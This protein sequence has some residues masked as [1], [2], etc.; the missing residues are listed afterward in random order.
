MKNKILTI[1]AIVLA[2]IAGAELVLVLTKN[3]NTTK[4]GDEKVKA[5][6]IIERIK[7]LTMELDLIS[8][9]RRK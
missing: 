6:R 5:R 9:N 7:Q 2:F 1:I 3:K 4:N 8:E